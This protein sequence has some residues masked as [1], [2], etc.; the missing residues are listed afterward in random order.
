MEP[1]GADLQATPGAYGTFK[2]KDDVMVAFVDEHY[3][4]YSFMV[5]YPTDDPERHE[6]EFWTED[7]ESECKGFSA[8]DSA[9]HVTADVDCE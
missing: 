8:V 6:A 7:E 1:S 5:V 9:C 2:A 4:G 3:G